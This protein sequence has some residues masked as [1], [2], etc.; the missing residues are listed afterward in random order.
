V[1]EQY[2]QINDALVTSPHIAV[3]YSSANVPTRDY[4]GRGE[5]A[6]TIAAYLFDRQHQSTRAGLA[7]LKLN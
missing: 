2:P 5:D 6:L 1:W 4:L 3:P 7:T